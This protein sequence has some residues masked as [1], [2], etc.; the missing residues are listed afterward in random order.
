[1]SDP[2]FPPPLPRTRPA[3]GIL[4]GMGPLATAEF[5]RR[6]VARTPAES[7]QGHLPV[8]MWA[9]PAV[10]DRTAALLGQGPSPV[11][12]LVAGARWLRQA[13]ARCV[14][15]PCN[16]AHAYLEQVSKAT[17]VE[18]LDM[19]QAALRVAADSVAGTS[20]TTRV[21]V[22]ATRGTRR[23][24]LYERAG[25]RLGVDVLHVPVA[26]QRAYVDPAIHAVK[27]G[28]DL[29]GPE[30]RIAAAAGALKARGAQVVIT[31]CTEIPLVSGAAAR[32]VPVVDSTDALVD[33]AVS[34]LWRAD[35]PGVSGSI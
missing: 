13:G 29:A 32:I 14:A 3:L 15:V 12:A 4:G 23:A 28:A 10:P 21:G 33:A 2:E 31:A 6:L 19:V 18:V 9:D 7:D 26:L 20:G 24:G 8:L 5:Y 22:L 25:A 11:P 1:M 30:Q 27:A 17:G 35:L 34:R 16:T